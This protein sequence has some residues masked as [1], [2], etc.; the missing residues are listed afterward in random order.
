MHGF[1]INQNNIPKS[2]LFG[3]AENNA[4]SIN[5]T[6]LFDVNIK[7]NNVIFCMGNLIASSQ[8]SNIIDLSSESL[9]NKQYVF[10]LLIII[11]TFM[12]IDSSAI[13]I[14]DESISLLLNID[15]CITK[16]IG[17][18]DA[19]YK[20]Y[21]NQTLTNYFNISTITNISTNSNRIFKHK[22]IYFYNE[23]FEKSFL[24]NGVIVF[25]GN[26]KINKSYKIMNK[27]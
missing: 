16:I 4:L 5:L 21:I 17:F 14:T 6:N 9:L 10:T 7:I 25:G 1:I 18:D 13:G 2:N 20:S 24:Y 12:Q 11:N 19:L 27:N 26:K 23:Q 15:A 8:S 3:M 22:Y